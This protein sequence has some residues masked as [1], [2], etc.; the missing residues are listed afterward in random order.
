MAGGRGCRSRRS[1]RLVELSPIGPTNGAQ[2]GAIISTSGQ[3]DMSSWRGRDILRVADDV[4]FQAVQRPNRG[5]VQ[6]S[7][8][9]FGQAVWSQWGTPASVSGSRRLLTTGVRSY[10]FSNVACPVGRVNEEVTCI[11]QSGVI[12]PVPGMVIHQLNPSGAREA[13]ETRTITSADVHRPWSFSWCP[14]D[15]SGNGQRCSGV[16]GAVG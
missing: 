15:E 7:G 12:V 5:Q 9:D 6:S 16:G 13:V 11:G 4:T 3:Q 8:E 10:G 1:I 2:R 14:T